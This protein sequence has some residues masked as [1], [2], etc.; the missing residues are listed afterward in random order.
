[1]TKVLRFQDVGMNSFNHYAYGAIGAWLYSVVAAIE[2][3]E[4]APG[5]KRIVFRPQ[6]G[7]D[8]THARATLHLLY[9]K[10]KSNWRVEEGALCWNIT[11]PPNTT[12]TVFVPAHEGTQITESGQA[13]DEAHSVLFLRGEAD[14][15]VF[16]VG[17]GEYSFVAQ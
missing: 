7:R 4:E 1:M 13:V 5:Y 8:I 9:G 6:A 11:V 2:V 12:A 14:A 3:D 16:E 15:E 10:I 17:A